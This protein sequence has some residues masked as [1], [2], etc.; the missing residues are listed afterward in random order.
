[1]A[2]LVPAIHLFQPSTSSRLRP[3]PCTWRWVLQRLIIIAAI[4]ISGFATGLSA[5][6]EAIGAVSERKVA[7]RARLASNP[8][9][10]P[11]A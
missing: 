10:S 7:R 11:M 5:R 2:G 3:K 6:P 1:M 8:R 9:C 4:V